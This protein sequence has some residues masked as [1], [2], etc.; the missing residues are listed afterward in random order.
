MIESS[1][2][3][4]ALYV[5]SR[6]EFAV[7][8]ELAKKRI[9]TFLPSVKKLSRWK[10]R[11]K[12]VQFPLF[13]GYL[14]VHIESGPEQ[15]RR[16]LK[17]PGAVNLVSLVPGQ[18]APVPVQEI[19]SLKIVIGSGEDFDIYPHLKEGSRVRIK[20]GALAGAEG[21]LM[22]KETQFL[23]LVNIEILGRSIGVK[24]HADEVELI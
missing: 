20:K 18:P 22:K 9:E 3:W 10:D 8:S 14:F 5:R 4:Y 24:V 2:N 11:N 23:F 17:T 13:P 19:D 12:L 7:E 6:H 1:F 21:V 16:V 15:F